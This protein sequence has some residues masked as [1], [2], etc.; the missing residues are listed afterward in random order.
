VGRRACHVNDYITQVV[1]SEFSA[2]DFR[3]W[4][5]TVLASAGFAGL[6]ARGSPRSRRAI[7]QVVRS[8][9]EHLGNTP[10]VCRSSYIDPRVIEC[11]ERG[12]TIGN[13][14]RT[15]KR[16]T[17]ERAVIAMLGGC[18]RSGPALSTSEGKAA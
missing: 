5:A 14:N 16:E 17:I 8:V 9:A 18:G 2:K 7:S 3:T 13:S 4:N 15:R 11:F 6:D 1:G 12:E 10:A